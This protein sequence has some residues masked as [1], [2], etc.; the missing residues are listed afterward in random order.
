MQRV[1]SLQYSSHVNGQFDI[2]NYLDYTR[3]VTLTSLYN[4]SMF[5]NHYNACSMLLK[6]ALKV[7]ALYSNNIPLELTL[8]G[9]KTYN[10]AYI[11]C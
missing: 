10:G 1:L 9:D 2:F 4:Q 3:M 7:S 6:L 8:F 11:Q 5:Q